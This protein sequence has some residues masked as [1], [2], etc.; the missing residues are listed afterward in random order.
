LKNAFQEFFLD[1]ATNVMFVF[2]GRTSKPYRGF[3][4]NRQIEFRNN[5]LED[6]ERNF[7]LYVDYITPRIYG[8]ATVRHGNES[9]SYNTRAVGPA[10][11][12]AERT[13]LMKGRYINVDDI[14]NR[15]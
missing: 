3:K 11:Q 5:D 14:N 7:S 6:I 4:S 8:Q 15:T 2:P 13:V 9:N 10:H 12:F 1:D